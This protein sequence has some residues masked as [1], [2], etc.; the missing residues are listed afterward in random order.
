MPPY[1]PR[2]YELTYNARGHIWKR[3]PSDGSVDIFA[4]TSDGDH[5]NGPQCVKCGYGFCHHCHQGP[6]TDCTADHKPKQ[7][8][9]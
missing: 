4:Y 7:Q 8:E 2:P 5:C 6:Q 1:S 9:T 3:D